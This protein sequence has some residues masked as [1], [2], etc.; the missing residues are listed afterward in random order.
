MK[1]ELV[2]RLLVAA[3]GIPLIFGAIL[4]GRLP[5]FIFINVVMV[6]ALWEFYHFV[7]KK[8]FVPA[9]I[10]GVLSVMALSLDIYLSNGTRFP[11]ILMVTVVF[12]LIVQLFKKNKN[13]LGSMASSLL[14]ILYVSL[15]SS[16]I[17]LR[18][19]KEHEN[20]PADVIARELKQH[21][22]RVKKAMTALR[23]WPKE[24]IDSALEDLSRLDRYL[25]TWQYDEKMLIQMFLIKFCI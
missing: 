1:N 15:F 3:I 7:E 9:R 18:K 21:P 2:K 12:I 4:Y 11:L 8:N 24:N 19:I 10:I 20:K 6:L 16:F 23:F 5:F 22:F 14:G 13:C 17:L 25:K